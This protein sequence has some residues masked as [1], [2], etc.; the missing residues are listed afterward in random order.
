[1]VKKL[2]KTSQNLDFYYLKSALRP[3]ITLCVAQEE[4]PG[5]LCSLSSLSHHIRSVFQRK[6]KCVGIRLL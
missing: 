3:H 4:I 5:I 2:K 6:M 1:M